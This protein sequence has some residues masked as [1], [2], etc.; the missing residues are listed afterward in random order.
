MDAVAVDGMDVLAVEAAVQTP[1]PRSYATGRSSSKRTYRLRAH[2]MFDAESYCSKSEVQE[3]RV[4]RSHRHLHEMLPEKGLSPRK[5]WTSWRSKSR[6][7]WMKPAFAEAARGSR[8]RIRPARP[9]EDALS[10][11]RR[12]YDLPPC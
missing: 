3:W 8:W 12:F 1:W 11:R 9:L 2:S 7:S 5:T 4:T 10:A 6:P